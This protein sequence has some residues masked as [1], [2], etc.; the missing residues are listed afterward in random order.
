MMVRPL[1]G[2]GVDFQVDDQDLRERL[3]LGGGTATTTEE[4]RQP[5]FSS[6]DFTTGATYDTVKSMLGDAGIPAGMAGDLINTWATDWERQRG[7]WPTLDDFLNDPTFFNQAQWTA[8]G[9]WA[10][11]TRFRVA[12]PDG[13][14]T[15]Y[16]N[17]R[18][19]GI[20]EIPNPSINFGSADRAERD[21]KSRGSYYPTFTPEQ[22]QSILS[23]G[24][25]LTRPSPSRGPSRG[26][27]GRQAPVFDEAQLREAATAIWRGLL[28]EE[29]DN[30]DPIVDE[31][32][33]K[34]SSFFVGQGGQLDFET[35]IREKALGSGRG[36][37]L[38]AKKPESLSHEQY[39]AQYVT[40]VRQLGL[41]ESEALPLI[42]SGATSGAGA[43]GFSDRLQRNTT[44]QVMNQGPIGQRMA[45]LLNATGL[46][47]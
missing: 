47:R 20:D 43:A 11:P 33:R 44:V 36:K 9:F 30:I 3:G 19:G 16:R 23:A 4:P 35:F 21:A 17:N 31:Y 45:N 26:S 12:N 10:L 14:F 34:A 25:T 5:S 42:E 8:G 24:T 7:R 32:V 2:I 6:A 18:T 22:V 15:Y 40:A 28:L 29:P 27:P 38:Y 39:L 46:G 13:T 37:L 41:R 1:T